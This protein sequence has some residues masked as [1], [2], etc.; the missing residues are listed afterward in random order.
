MSMRDDVGDATT[1]SYPATLALGQ[2]ALLGAKLAQRWTTLVHLQAA[3]FA[4]A[5]CPVAQVPYRG[6]SNAARPL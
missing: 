1:T 4:A 2:S 3:A 6:G 5:Q